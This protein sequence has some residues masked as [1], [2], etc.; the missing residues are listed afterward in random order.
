MNIVF[1]VKSRALSKPQAAKKRKIAKVFHE[2][3]EGDLHSGS[4]HGP[5]VPYQGKVN[6]QA[7]AIALHSGKEAA[8][9]ARKKGK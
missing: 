1:L 9:K 2:W 6:K 4:K 8:K 5:K 3:G 7:V